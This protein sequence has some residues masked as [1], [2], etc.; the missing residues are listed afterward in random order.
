M[1]NIG[2]GIFTSGCMYT[3]IY[4]CIYE[5]V[6]IMTVCL[7]VFLY[8]SMYDFAN[9]LHAFH[10]SGDDDLPV[11][12]HNAQRSELHGHCVC[13]SKGTPYLNSST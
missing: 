5:H 3:C 10:S 7:Y 12:R 1:R 11:S 6:I 9:G 8:V 4:A 2:P 13:T